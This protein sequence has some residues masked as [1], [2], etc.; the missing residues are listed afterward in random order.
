MSS[1]DT[2]LG[3]ELRLQ[4]GDGNSPETFADLCASNDVSG[5][6]ENKPQIDVTTQCDEGRTYRGGLPE[7]ADVTVKTNFIQ[8]DAQVRALY[9]AYSN[10]EAVNFRL[11]VVGSSPEEY[12]AFRTTIL[13]WN[14]TPPVGAKA[15]LTFNMKIS[16][17]VLWVYA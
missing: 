16:G 10:N 1:E 17:R 4:I 14:V 5:L 11:S 9:Q 6:G 7:G 2:L 13:G 12:F 15:E 3:N 8:G